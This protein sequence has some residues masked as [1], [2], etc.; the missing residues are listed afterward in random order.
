MHTRNLHDGGTF[1]PAAPESGYPRAQPPFVEEMPARVPGFVHLDPVRDGA[2]G[3]PFYRKN[4][5]GGG[6]GWTARTGSKA[7][8]SLGRPPRVLPGGS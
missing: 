8:L 7:Q 4:E 3:D 6:S 1:R 2:I 5:I